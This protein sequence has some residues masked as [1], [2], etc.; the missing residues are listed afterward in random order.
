MDFLF[1]VTFGSKIRQICYI[2]LSMEIT[3]KE[4]TQLIHE[5]KSDTFWAHFLCFLFKNKKRHGSSI[6]N[7]VRLW[8]YN[9][10]TA[11]LYAVF[12]FKFNRENHLIDI[13]TKP[14][15]FGKSFFLGVFLILFFFFSWRLSTLHENE[16]FWLYTFIIAA[17]MIMYVVFCKVVYESERR[18]QQKKFFEKLDIEVTEENTIKERSLFS[19]F[20]RII[21][22]PIGLGTLY[23]SIFHFFPNHQYEYAILGMAGVSAY[24]I[25]DIILLFRWKK[26]NR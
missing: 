25:T 12:I 16:R 22:Y 19:V 20:I 15:I 10:W 18:I 21:T 1:L 26:K 24:F 9:S 17:F 11:S 8:Q 3:K 5:Q 23:A 4:V 7:E 14:N 2:I 13:K 6:D